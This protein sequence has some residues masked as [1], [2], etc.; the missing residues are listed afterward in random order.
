MN[1]VVFDFYRQAALAHGFMIDRNAPWQLVANIDSD[2][3]S[4][5][6]SARGTSREELWS[7]HY[8]RVQYFDID[9]MKA[10]FLTMWNAF[11]S[12]NPYS[13]RREPTCDGKS[14][15]P[16]TT[17]RR[18]YRASEFDQKF[19]NA[20]WIDLYCKIKSYECQLQSPISRSTLSM[21]TKNA[22]RLEK[23]LDIVAAIDYINDQ[24]I[25]KILSE[26][27]SPEKFF[28]RAEPTE[29]GQASQY[30][31]NVIIETSDY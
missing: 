31:S 1:S 10:Q 25:D 15:K 24:F 3:M 29:K 13:T 21:I 2:A 4:A 30:Q 16:M 8:Y 18:S 20:F 12:K 6:M 11:V 9:E 22:I 14:T 5:Y 17:R 19:D 26:R 23:S 7:T 27:L 28:P